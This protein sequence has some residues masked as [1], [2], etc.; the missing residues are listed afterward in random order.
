MPEP[1]ISRIVLA[2]HFVSPPGW[3]GRDHARRRQSSGI[4]CVLDGCAEYIMADGS[5]FSVHSGEC[6]YIPRGSEYTT[7]C[8]EQESFTH[9]TV[10]FELVGS[11]EFFP[12]LVRRRLSN[13][14]QFEQLFSKLIHYW[15]VRH[16][17]YHE[18]CVG[19]LY[20]MVYFLLKEFTQTGGP[21]L[22]KV[23]P[24]RVYLDEHFT[25][26]FELRQLAALCGLSEPYFRRLFLRVFHETPAEYR[27]RLR[28]AYAEN[29]L[30]S[31][32]CTVSQAAQQC[33][34]SDPAYF[35]RI[36]RKTL[37]VSPSQYVG[38]RLGGE[39]A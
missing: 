38:E 6:I 30:L 29:L 26:E 3:C 25:E 15:T 7:Q 4:V 27:R 11:E 8:G 39:E 35:S 33:G 31:G 24:A 1:V 14:V 2:H 28:I 34:Y 23:L 36:F 9:M 17:F 21:Y 13:P 19:V 32:S 12:A 5:R 37:G 18:R 20:E 10:N 22:K 16:P